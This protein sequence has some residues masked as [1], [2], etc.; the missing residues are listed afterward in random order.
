MVGWLNRKM[1][2]E[3]GDEER[4]QGWTALVMDT[5]GNGRR[6]AYVEPNQRV[7]PSKD[8]RYKRRL[9]CCRSSA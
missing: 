4:S 6:D 1:F 9:L 7:D 8:T 3:T 2:E 5:N